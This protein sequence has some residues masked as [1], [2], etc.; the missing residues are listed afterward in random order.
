MKLSGLLPPPLLQQWPC[1]PLSHRPCPGTPGWPAQGSGPGP[2]CCPVVARPHPLSHT[3]APPSAVV[4]PSPSLLCWAG[5]LPLA[6]QV[7]LQPFEVG[8]WGPQGVTC[9]PRP[10]FLGDRPLCPCLSSCNRNQV[11]GQLGGEDLAVPALTGRCWPSLGVTGMKPC[12]QARESCA[13]A[14]CAPE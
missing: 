6:G 10:P 14:L 7:G 2:H 3:L 5:C 11:S 4:F 12:L 13:H 8:M 9:T 1:E